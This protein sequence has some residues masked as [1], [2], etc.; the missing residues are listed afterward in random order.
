VHAIA[1]LFG[2]VVA[3]G[4]ALVASGGSCRRF[5]ARAGLAPAFDVA[6]L[7]PVRRG[8]YRRRRRVGGPD[9]PRDERAV[10]SR[11]RRRHRPR[12]R[13]GD[14]RRIST[15]GGAYEFSKQDP[16]NL[17][18]LGILQQDSRRVPALLADRVPY[19]PRSVL[20]AAPGLAAYV[21]SGPRTPGLSP[22]A[23]GVGIELELSTVLHL[24]VA[25]AY[26]PLYLL[27]WVDSSTTRHDAGVAHIVGI[28][29]AIEAQDRIGPSRASQTGP[30]A[31][32]SAEPTGTLPRCQSPQVA[33]MS[34]QSP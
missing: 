27:A 19:E 24:G 15:S 34:L 6:L 23:I 3:A 7:R 11:L 33:A 25:V 21:T 18:R 30:P 13:A 26:R 8:F 4:L 5:F 29:L 10:H 28:E 17:Y 2:V 31:I 1:R 12:A 16:N 20:I 9:L 22:G 14:P 32:S